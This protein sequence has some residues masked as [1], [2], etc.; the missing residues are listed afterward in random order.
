[1]ARRPEGRKDDVLTRDELEELQQR[2]SRLSIVA[3][4]DFYRSAHHRCSLQPRWLPPTSGRRQRATGGTPCLGG[5]RQASSG[6][7]EPDESRGS[8]PDLWGTRGVTPRVYPAHRL[9]SSSER[10]PAIGRGPKIQ[11][12]HP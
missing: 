11:I 6:W 3:V 10:N 4:E 2:L 7:H 8:R 5:S 12:V 1:M 9:V